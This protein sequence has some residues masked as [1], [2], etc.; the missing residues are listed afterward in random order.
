MAEK[1][2][3]ANDRPPPA[4]ADWPTLIERAVDDVSR[5]LRSEALMLQTSMGAALELKIS[6]MMTLLTVVGILISGGLCILGAAIFLLHQW[7]PL[8][9]SFGIAGLVML[10]V[11]IASMAAMKPRAE[12]VRA[13]SL[14]NK[15][16]D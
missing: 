3:P 6:R 11:G 2:D 9:E 16:L 8:W 15:A 14:L 4:Y 13:A 1:P 12:V 10:L 5:I 7:L